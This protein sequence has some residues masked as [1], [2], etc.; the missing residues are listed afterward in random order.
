[1]RQTMTDDPKVVRLSTKRKSV[2]FDS[3]AGA[4]FALFSDCGTEL[5]HAAEQARARGKPAMEILRD[6]AAA[7]SLAAN[8]A[9]Y[10]NEDGTMRKV[11]LGAKP[12]RH[13]G[14]RKPMLS[15]KQRQKFDAEVLRA[16]SEKKLGHNQSKF[17][18]RMLDFCEL[19]FGK[20]PEPWTVKRWIKDLI[21]S[22]QWKTP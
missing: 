22:E 18:Q 13:A 21:P 11:P 15:V 14:G 12:K 4:I 19:T 1:M 2:K 3:T 5:R 17:A 7:I 9:R 6:N 20:A 10:F 16:K 8:R